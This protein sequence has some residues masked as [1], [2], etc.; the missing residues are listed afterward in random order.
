MDNL[1]SYHH[2][3]TYSLLC[4]LYF[5][6]YSSVLNF[7]KKLPFWSL[8]SYVLAKSTVK[9]NLL[10]AIIT[11]A[12]TTFCYSKLLWKVFFHFRYVYS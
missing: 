10:V 4:C 5:L 7:L 12:N 9:Y 8:M 11:K 3:I 2:E 6:P 1:Y